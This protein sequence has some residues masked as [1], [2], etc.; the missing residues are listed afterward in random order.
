MNSLRVISGSARGFHLRSVPGD[1][2][3]PITDR[4]K[5]ALFNIL[6]RD[7]EGSTFLDVFGGT[8]AVGIEALSRGA[9]YARF[10]EINRQAVETIHANLQHTHLAEK[11][12]VFRI[13]AFSYLKQ[14]PDRPFDYIFVAP[15][16]YKE[17]W[18]KTM[19]VLGEN[20]GWLAPG[21]LLIVQVDP[22]EYRQQE[23]PQF[24]L[25]EQRRYGSTLILFYEAAAMEGPI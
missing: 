19:A 3:R 4:V 11:A 9:A 25:I 21:G 14:K 10:L 12:D 24:E 18:L 17:L 2:T 23:F 16:Q 13:D 22:V 8:G 1:T 20:P 5:E 6:G 7:V 15:P